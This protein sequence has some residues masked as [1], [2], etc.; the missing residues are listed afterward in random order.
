MA[1]SENPEKITYGQLWDS[2][3]ED[4]TPK[5]NKIERIFNPDSDYN[6]RLIE[7]VQ[8]CKELEPDMDEELY[9]LGFVEKKTINYPGFVT[10]GVEDFYYNNKDDYVCIGT[11]SIT[12]V[13]FNDKEKSFDS[14]IVGENKRLILRW[15]R[16]L[17]NE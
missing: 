2:V 13:T 15:I 4:Y 11:D 10:P 17:I 12:V 1:D 7:Y 16:E 9:K 5:G 14:D 3:F 8:L 6:K